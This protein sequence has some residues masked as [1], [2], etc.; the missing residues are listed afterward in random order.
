M[1][2]SEQ[3]AQPEK[4]KKK[5]KEEPRVLAGSKDYDYGNLLNGK[6]IPTKGGYK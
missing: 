5:P 3:Q 1:R 6:K 2:Y 4:P